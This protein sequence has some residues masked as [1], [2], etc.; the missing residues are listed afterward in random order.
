MVSDLVREKA[1]QVVDILRELDVDAWLVWVRE[2]SQMA[3][4][5]LELIF[6][7]DLVWQSALMFS[8]HGERIAIVGNA[9][10]DAIKDMSLFDRVTPYTKSIRDHLVD[11]LDRLSP[12]RIAI[13]YSRNDVSS[14]GLTYGMY[15]LLKDNL[16]DT[17]HEERLVSA[18]DVIT[19]LRGRK[20]SGETDR[21]R[22]AVEITEDI[23]NEVQG[24]LKV[25]MTEKEIHTLFHQAMARH[26][27][28]GAWYPDHNPAVDAG[29]RKQFGHSGP[30]SNKTKAG[31]LLHFDFGVRYESYCSDLQRMFFFGKPSEVPEEVQHA[32]ETVRDAIQAASNFI[33]AGSVGHEVDNIARNHVLERGYGEYQ[34]ALGHQIGRQAHDGGTI[35]GPLWDRYGDTPMGVVEIGNA[36]TLELNVATKNYG[37]VSL[38]EDIIITRSGCEFLSRPQKELICVF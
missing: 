4:P 30:T 12:T 25:G 13:N 3:D 36:F 22:K 21:I 18:E 38:E 14:D 6:G 20:T 19:R 32:F 1:D 35:L 9:D 10:A 16:R 11:E 8:R 15:M 29:P 7:A 2:T 27:V 33:K 17:P 24:L 23:F 34:H 28:T 5:A 26:G 31:H 37:Q